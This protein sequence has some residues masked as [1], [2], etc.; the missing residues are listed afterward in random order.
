MINGE[1]VG[2]DLGMNTDNIVNLFP[3]P[4]T[5]M[6]NVIVS[7]DANVQLLDVSGSEVVANTLVYANQ[8]HE[9]NTANLA[10]GVYMLKVSNNNFVS[11]KKV[12]VQK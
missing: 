12:V 8:K 2:V 9:I 11:I 7:E 1:R 3:N 10:S 5:D 6:L 4:A